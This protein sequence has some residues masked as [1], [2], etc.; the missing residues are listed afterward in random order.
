MRTFFALDLTPKAKIAIDQWRSKTQPFQEGKVPMANF[1]ITLCFNGKT[2]QQQ[3]QQLQAG[4]DSISVEA[5]ALTLNEFG[6]WTKPSISFIA[7]REIPTQ[8][9]SLHNN[10]QRLSRQQGLSTE[11]RQYMPHVTLCRRLQQPPAP[12]LFAPEF[13]LEFQGF[14]LFESV[15]HKDKV[16]YNPIFSWQLKSSKSVR[17]RLASGEF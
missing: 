6:Y 13:Q 9:I 10:L 2:T 11:K 5:F 1:H 14:S 17:E 8:L 16:Q 4:A 15:N 7:P 12:P 3:L